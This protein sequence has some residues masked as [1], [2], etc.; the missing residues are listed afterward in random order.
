M[1]D[2]NPIVRPR[3]LILRAAGCLA[4]ASAAVMCFVLNQRYEPLKRR[5][6][7]SS[8]VTSLDFNTDGGCLLC[9][10]ES[11][12]VCVRDVHNPF[13]MRSG[14]R[15]SIDLSN[16]RI[17]SAT[18]TTANDVLVATYD[19]RFLQWNP[20]TGILACAATGVDGIHSAALLPPH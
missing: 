5:V 4:L 9:R 19:G 10:D 3:L 13:D 18:W 8:C 7:L 14:A 6:S 20:N 16:S 17:V 15:R 12:H 11:G 1:S 2:R